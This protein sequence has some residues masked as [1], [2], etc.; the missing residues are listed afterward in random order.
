[1]T[2]SEFQTSDDGLALLNYLM[3]EEELTAEDSLEDIKDAVAAWFGAN[4]T[5]NVG[6][7]VTAED[8]AKSMKQ[9]LTLLAQED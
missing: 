4:P 7:E 3:D 8:V 5:I 1:M 6:A 9:T 2:R